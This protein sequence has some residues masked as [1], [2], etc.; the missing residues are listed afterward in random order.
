MDM[1]LGSQ[2]RGRVLLGEASGEVCGLGG[3]WDL[4]IVLGRC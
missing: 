3:R 2:R 4:Q 1:P